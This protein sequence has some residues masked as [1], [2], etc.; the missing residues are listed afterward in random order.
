MG[1]ATF[2]QVMALF[3]LL[4]SRMPMKLTTV[5]SAISRMLKTKPAPVTSLVLSL[6][7]P[8]Q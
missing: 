4:N 8:C 1:I 6:N 7:R 3:T 5:N 2:H